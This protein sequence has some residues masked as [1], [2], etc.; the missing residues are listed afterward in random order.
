MRRIIPLFCLFFI[1]IFMSAQSTWKGLRFGMSEEEILKEYKGALRKQISEKSETQL[2]TENVELWPS[3]S[4]SEAVIAEGRFTLGSGNKLQL[5]DLTV[6][7]ENISS[8]TLAMTSLLAQRIS[9]KYGQP[10][11][12]KGECNATPA[13]LIRS[14][15]LTCIQSWK[16]EGQTIR[17]IWAV[18]RGRFTNL[19]ITYAPTPIEF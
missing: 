14:L 7:P 18:T 6:R 17:L 19:S 12:M 2:V 1:P 13:T 3:V 11:S 4:G 5:I 16:G 10:V 15:L 9:E 8:T